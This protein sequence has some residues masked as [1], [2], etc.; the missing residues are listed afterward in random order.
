[1]KNMP[2]RQG[3]EQIGLPL[4]VYSSHVSYTIAKC[5]TT[6]VIAWRRAGET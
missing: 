2:V 5:D 1:M 6:D 4:A 3:H